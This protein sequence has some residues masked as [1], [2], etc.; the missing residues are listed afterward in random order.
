MSC[1]FA[2]SVFLKVVSIIEPVSKTV[3]L[4]TIY[5][6]A[7]LCRHRMPG[8]PLQP[9]ESPESANRQPSFGQFEPC[10]TRGLG[11]AYRVSFRSTR[12]SRCVHMRLPGI[13]VC[14]NR[15]PS[16]LLPPRCVHGMAPVSGGG[17]EKLRPSEVKSS[18]CRWRFS[19][20]TRDILRGPRRQ[21]TIQ[22][23]CRASACTRH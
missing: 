19:E 14:R 13:K 8:L 1:G 5:L 22:S 15:K 12:P 20:Y 6:F 3:H 2:I 17:G 16:K 18:Y 11:S 10:L 4:F 9:L 7:A 21:S 23:V